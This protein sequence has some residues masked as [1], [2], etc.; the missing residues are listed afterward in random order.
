MTT[1]QQHLGTKDSGKIGT[2]IDRIDH[3]EYKLILKRDNS[4]YLRFN[5][6]I[7]NSK[8]RSDLIRLKFPITIPLSEVQIQFQSYLEIDNPGRFQVVLNY[9][10]PKTH[11]IHTHH[12]PIPKKITHNFKIGDIVSIKMRSGERINRG[13]VVIGF[14]SDNQLIVYP[15]LKRS[16]GYADFIEGGQF[17]SNQTEIFNPDHTVN[18][19]AYFTK[20]G[21]D[22]ER[23]RQKAI[24][25][26]R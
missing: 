10:S 19:S 4:E 15:L 20:K 8:G 5:P 11:T 21:F 12:I 3:T 18:D 7:V 13:M 14:T 17:Y 6:V 1:I 26:S 22:K 25:L 23:I 2:L 9:T 24:Q 16:V